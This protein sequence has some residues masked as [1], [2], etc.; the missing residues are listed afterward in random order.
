M[1]KK[2]KKK[3]NKSKKKKWQNS[4]FDSIKI[5]Y[6]NMIND[7]NILKDEQIIRGHAYLI[8]QDIIKKMCLESGKHDPKNKLCMCYR[9]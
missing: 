8:S 7:P 4:L 9:S 6:N 3:L 2:S 1:N 5:R